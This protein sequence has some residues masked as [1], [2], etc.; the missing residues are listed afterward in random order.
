MRRAAIRLVG[1]ILMVLA[2]Q[3]ALAD[4]TDLTPQQM[5]VLGFNF[6]TAGDTAA[7]MQVAEALLERNPQDAAALMLRAQI[8]DAMQD[9]RKA[10]G[11]ARLAF[12]AADD[13]QTQYAA[14]MFLADSFTAEGRL[15][16]AQL[17]L[18]QAS[19]VAPDDMSYTFARERF[20]YAH[21]R[22]PWV[23][24]FNFEIQPT[25]NVNGGSQAQYFR[26]PGIP[27][28]PPEIPIAGEQQALSGT[29]T[30]LTA[31]A[32]YRLPPTA[33]TRTE[34]T[35]AGYQQLTYLSAEAKQLAPE[36]DASFF[37]FSTI[38]A[39]VSRQYKP[40][41]GDVIYGAGLYLGHNWQGGFDQGNTMR[42]EGSFDALLSNT[43][44]GLGFVSAEHQDRIDAPIRS[45]DTYSIAMGLAHQFANADILQG[46]V[47]HRDTQSQSPG[48]T[49]Q[50][51]NIRFLWNKAEPVAGM[52]LS[53]TAVAE[54]RN[55]PYS[56]YDPQNGRQDVR[57]AATMVL[58]LDNFEYMGFAPTLNLSYA[59]TD[60]TVA[61]FS[62]KELGISL[63]FVSSF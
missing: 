24:R 56:P 43:T 58:E 26:N 33:T 50:A 23:F 48:I 29:I 15:L 39:G 49:N 20:G 61:L 32:T 28:L 14:A 36:A 54:Y 27:W 46:Y 55:Y 22:S 38:V 35:L 11:S 2:A 41:N 17:W 8:Y 6:L 53:A 59:Q 37:N 18:R 9:P 31:L 60:S 30:Q 34:F 63:G 51:Y 4:S 19:Q 40:L 62:S 10:R 57:L 16:N 25:N 45:S 47:G 42:L 5:R 13:M 52:D 1:L 21:S 44:H 7:A 12:G 3:P